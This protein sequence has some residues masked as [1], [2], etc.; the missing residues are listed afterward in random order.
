MRIRLRLTGGIA[1]AILWTAGAFL[2][3]VPAKALMID[4]REVPLHYETGTGPNTAYTLVDFGGA[5]PAGDR[6]LLAYHFDGSVTSAEMLQA[7]DAAG[8]L[9]LNLLDFGF[10]LFVNRIEVGEDLD[11]PAFAEDERYW[12]FWLGSYD[13]AQG[14]QVLWESSLVGINDRTL[15]NQTVDGWYASK[16]GTQPQFPVP[17]PI[18]GSLGVALATA[19]WFL[20]RT[21]RGG[22][23]LS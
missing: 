2:H 13:S 16:G 20:R 15:Q 11:E 14:G 9:N 4:G 18:G 7:L 5:D 12:E 8:D 22:E 21:L 23:P 3:T 17:E 1:G 10:G 6:Y 19:A